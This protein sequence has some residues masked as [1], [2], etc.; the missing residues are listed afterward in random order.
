MRRADKN[1]V[2]LSSSAKFFVFYLILFPV[3]FLYGGQFKDVVGGGGEGLINFFSLVVAL[4]VL[5]LGFPRNI[6]VSSFFVLLYFFFVCFLSLIRVVFEGVWSTPSYI[7]YFSFFVL[8]IFAFFSG[9]LLIDKRVISRPSISVVL[10]FILFSI[11]VFFLF[12]NFLGFYVNKNWAALGGFLI[13]LLRVIINSKIYLIDKLIFTVY[14]VVSQFVF[15]SQGVALASGIVSLGSIFSFWTWRFLLPIV[16]IVSYTSVLVLISF[17]FFVGWFLGRPM[18]VAFSA[19]WQISFGERL[20]SGRVEYWIALV[21]MIHTKEFFFGYGLDATIDAITSGK[22]NNISTHNLFTEVFLRTGF[23]GLI[24]LVL[25][26]LSALHGLLKSNNISML[27]VL[28]AILILGSVYSL[29]LV[30][31]WPGTVI[32][33]LLFGALVRLG[34]GKNLTI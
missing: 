3:M 34:R 21:D 14:A 16:S 10:F 22:L 28:I 24:L 31:H 27:L 6:G 4:S 13:I 19:W 5:K 8:N 29:G 11:F 33:W 26:I 9:V 2:F 15:D 1:M 20:G 25:A 23:F 12:N 17:P 18:G 7:L 32:F 30:T